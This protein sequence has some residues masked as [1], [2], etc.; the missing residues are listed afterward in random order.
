MSSLQHPSPS[1]FSHSQALQYLRKK[2]KRWKPNLY[3]V[4]PKVI[5]F[6]LPLRNLCLRYCGDICICG[7]TEHLDFCM[8]YDTGHTWSWHSH[9]Q[10]Q[11]ACKGHWQSPKR[12]SQYTA[13]LPRSS[14]SATWPGCLTPRWPHPR[15]SLLL[16][17]G[18]L[19]NA[20]LLQFQP[21]FRK[22]PTIGH[23]YN[24][25]TGRNVC[26]CWWQFIQRCWYF[27]LWTDRALRVLQNFPHCWH[28]WPEESMCFASMWK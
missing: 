3:C 21:N 14:P 5:R 25:L 18:N 11:C 1:R 7:Q 6:V 22:L 28:S 24:K 19:A 10:T 8:T 26:K 17:S 16:K 2:R 13:T 15:K 20:K 12:C 4:K 9:V 23:I 27:D